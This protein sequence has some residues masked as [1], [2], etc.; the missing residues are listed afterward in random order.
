MK[1]IIVQLVIFLILFSCD[2]QKNPLSFTFDFVASFPT[3]PGPNFIVIDKDSRFLYIS[4]SYSA[5]NDRNRKIQKFNLKGELLKTIVDFTFF[6]KGNY[7]RYEPIDMT[8]DD[9]QNLYVLV[10]PY[11]KYS[12]ESWRALEGFCILKYDSENIFQKEFVFAQFTQEWYP[13]SIACYNNEIYVTN[14]QILKK[15]FSDGEQL[16]EIALPISVDNVITFPDIH[17]TDMA[18]NSNGIIYLVGQA[19]FDNKTVG[20]HL[21]IIDT[22]NNKRSTVYSKVR[23]ESFAAMLNNPGLTIG[24]DGFIYLATFYCKS[25]EIYNE[26]GDFIKQLD[27][28]SK[29]NRE[30]LPI[31]VAVDNNSI[32]IVDSFN[33][34]VNVYKKI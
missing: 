20:C 1:K 30:T 19:A 3:E 7:Q 33:N 34:C 21:T 26:N 23:T 28:T 2:R 24:C 13:A 15:I 5:A 6:D 22:K 32:Y 25:L 17:T 16:D 29:N 4:N 9:F 10:K 14:G 27:L 11:R 8:L 12:E 18:I 31:D